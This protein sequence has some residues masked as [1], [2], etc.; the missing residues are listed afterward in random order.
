MVRSLLLSGFLGC[1]LVGTPA[2]AQIPTDTQPAPVLSQ[3]AGIEVLNL[4]RGT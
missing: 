4:P 3:V 1:L 2:A